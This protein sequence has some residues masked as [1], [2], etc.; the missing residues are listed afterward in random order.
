MLHFKKKLRK[1]IVIVCS[2]LLLEK[3]DFQRNKMQTD[4][5]DRKII[6]KAQTSPSK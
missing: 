1:K 6:E 5:V 2:E 4:K 3:G